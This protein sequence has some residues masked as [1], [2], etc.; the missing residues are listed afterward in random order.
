MYDAQRSSIA[1]DG[2]FYNVLPG[3][4]AWIC[5]IDEVKDFGLALFVEP[6]L[7]LIAEHI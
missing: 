3:T 5:F 4:A 2:E 6:G 7:P 1:A